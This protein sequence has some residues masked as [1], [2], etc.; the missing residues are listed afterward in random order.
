MIFCIKKQTV[1]NC[2]FFL[3][4]L[5]TVIFRGSSG[6]LTEK[7]SAVAISGKTIVVDPGHGTPDGGAVADDGTLEKDINLTVSKK[8]GSLLQQ[9]GA[10]VVYTR[11][12]DNAVTDNLNDKIRKIKLDDLKN[13]K[14][15]AQKSN[16]DIF[17]SIHMNK[18]SDKSYSGAQVFYQGKSEKSKILAEIIQ[19]NM[20]KIADNK[21]R[22]EAKDSKTSI[23]VLNDMKMPAVL[24]ECGFLSNDEEKEKLLNDSYTDKIAYSIY[25]GIF[26]Y[27]S[28][29]QT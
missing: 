8:L 23:F 13:R 6:I 27:I 19:K 3:V 22:R 17:I 28:N 24:V 16:A 21:N 10:N 5:C 29:N 20:R 2:I 12:N 26:E 18:F 25:C 4:L 15:I 1:Y 11:E 9:S 14:K 7:T